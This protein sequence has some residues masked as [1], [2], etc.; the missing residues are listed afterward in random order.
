MKY[1]VLFGLCVAA[2]IWAQ[3]KTAVTGK[4]GAG[5][6]VQEIKVHGKS[7]EGNLEGDDTDRTVAVYL[8]PG[9]TRDRN[10]RYPVV[11]LLHGYGRTAGDWYPF[12]GLPGSMDRNIAAGT[13]HEMIIV[14][15]DA[16]TLYGGS[17]YSTSP[18]SGDWETYITHDLVA[19]IDSHYRTIAKRESRG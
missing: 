14:I 12:I 4:A 15:P 9:Y 16:N 10:K 19:Y 13:A 8:P 18:T 17:M 11:Y 5:G 3:E 1:A 6:Q 7:L 2:A